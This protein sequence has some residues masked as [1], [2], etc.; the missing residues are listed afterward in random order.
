M[1]GQYNPLNIWNTRSGA[2]HLIQP[3]NSLNAEIRIAADATIL[4]KKCRWHTQDR[5]TGSDQLC[6]VRRSGRASDP[7]IGDLVNGLARM[8][9]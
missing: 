4:R 9:M 2:M 7:H 8:A 1:A 5:R 3:S 6:T